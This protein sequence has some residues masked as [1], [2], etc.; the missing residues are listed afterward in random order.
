MHE[1]MSIRAIVRPEIDI[2]VEDA[3][4]NW[5]TYAIGVP[6]VAATGATPEECRREMESAL[7]ARFRFVAREDAEE[8]AREAELVRAELAQQEQNAAAA[9]KKS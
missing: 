2:F 8:F 3:G 6:G 1:E 9:V 4:G 7:A 5:S